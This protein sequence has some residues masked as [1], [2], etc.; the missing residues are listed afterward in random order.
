MRP[1]FPGKKDMS[2]TTI[3]SSPHSTDSGFS[4]LETM[5]ALMVVLV[6]AAGLLPLGV[7]AFSTSENQ[8]HLSA[9]AAEYAQDKLEQLMALSYGDSTS[10]TRV[11]PAPELGGTGLTVGGSSNPALPIPQYVDYLDIDGSLIPSP[12]GAPPA[13]WYYQRV[14]QVTS[15]QANL[16]Q[17]TVTATVARSAGAW[18]LRPRATVTALKTFPF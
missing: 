8:G 18:A 14:W 15:P 12:T 9:R 4:L 10:D 16:K 3:P 2:N 6:A 13:G 1:G 17:I 11:F 7:V 5:V